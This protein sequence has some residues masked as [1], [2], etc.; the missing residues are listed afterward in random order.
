[1]AL[2][3]GKSQVKCR[4]ITL[5][6]KTAIHVS[7]QFTNVKKIMLQLYFI[8]LNKRFY[9]QAKFSIKQMKDGLNTI[10]CEGIGLN[11]I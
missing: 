8:I 1:M 2:A 9:F 4:E 3:N 7:E 6:T 10:V 11:T 5:H